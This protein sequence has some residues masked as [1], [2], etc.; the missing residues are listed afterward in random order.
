[1]GSRSFV[2]DATM[3][4]NKS[5]V[6]SVP[7][8]AP[9]PFDTS[10]QGR[11]FPLTCNGSLVH[12]GRDSVPNHFIYC[13]WQITIEWKSWQFSIFYFD[14][15]CC[16]HRPD[17]T[18]NDIRMNICLIDCLFLMI[19]SLGSGMPSEPLHAGSDYDAKFMGT[20]FDWHAALLSRTEFEL[21]EAWIDAANTAISTLTCQ[22]ISHCADPNSLQINLIFPKNGY[23]MLFRSNRWQSHW[24]SLNL[25]FCKID[26]IPN[27]DAFSTVLV[28]WAAAS[29]GNRRAIFT[30]IMVPVSLKPCALWK[31]A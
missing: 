17:M 27:G 16:R 8:R 24:N 3:M 31:F 28:G 14:I 22:L 29:G 21:S 25:W 11:V 30:T 4:T 7:R 23:G 15:L 13:S 5:R 10:D 6:R 26:I 18:S 9:F 12:C 20:V 19:T 1:M 2:C